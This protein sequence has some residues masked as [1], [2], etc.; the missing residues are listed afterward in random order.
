MAPDACHWVTVK[1]FCCRLLSSRFLS[2]VF[3]RRVGGSCGKNITD[4]VCEV[5][6]WVVGRRVLV[7]I[8]LIAAAKWKQRSTRG[9]TSEVCGNA[10]LQQMTLMRARVLDVWS[11]TAQAQS[12]L[13]RDW[14][15]VQFTDWNQES[16]NPTKLSSTLTI[17]SSGFRLKHP[18]QNLKMFLWT[19]LLDK[20]TLSNMKERDNAYSQVCSQV[21][22]SFIKHCSQK[23][24]QWELKQPNRQNKNDVLLTSP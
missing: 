4:Q 6:G 10:E 5:G 23:W 14:S 2:H 13:S 24:R 22:N 12:N 9:D 18:T 3:P 17:Q 16:T 21:V 1:K 20:M 11:G 19:I 15:E 8:S 7:I